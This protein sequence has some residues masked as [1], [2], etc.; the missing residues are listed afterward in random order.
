LKCRWHEVAGAGAL[1][2]FAYG[3]L[4]AL[5]DIAVLGSASQFAIGCGSITFF[6]GFSLAFLKK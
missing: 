5:F 6:G 1:R 2:L 4:Q 3:V